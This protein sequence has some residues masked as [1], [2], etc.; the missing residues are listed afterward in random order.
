VFLLIRGRTEYLPSISGGDGHH[1]LHLGL[2]GRLIRLGWDA[3]RPRRLSH[4]PDEALQASRR[5][6]EQQP[7]R[8]SVNIEGVGDVLRAKEKR[9]RV[10]L[11]GLI[12]YVEG[13]LALV[14]REKLLLEAARELGHTKLTKKVSRSLNKALNVEHNKRRLKTDWQLVWKPRKK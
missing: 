10:R 4:F 13:H 5:E 3:Q 1:L 6:D 9:A 7:R 11:Y 12:T 14:Q 8:S 2:V